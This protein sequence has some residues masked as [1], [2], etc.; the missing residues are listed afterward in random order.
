MPA[1][2]SLPSFGALEKHIGKCT[3]NVR[4]SLQFTHAGIS[5]SFAAEFLPEHQRRIMKSVQDGL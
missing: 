1:A 5:G 3:V 4:A 2:K